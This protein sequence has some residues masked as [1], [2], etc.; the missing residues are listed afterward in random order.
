MKS[1]IFIDPVIWGMCS[2][3]II[4]VSGFFVAGFFLSRENRKLYMYIFHVI[5]SPFLVLMCNIHWHIHVWQ[6]LASGGT[7]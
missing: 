7:N 1:H 3:D 2:K 6:Q 5:M 4:V